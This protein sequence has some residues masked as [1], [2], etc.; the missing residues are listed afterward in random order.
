MRMKKCE[1]CSLVYPDKIEKCVRCGGKLNEYTGEKKKA[2]PVEDARE[3]SHHWCDAIRKV[4][5]YVGVTIIFIGTTIAI[6]TGWEERKW[7]TFLIMMFIAFVT[8]LIFLVLSCVMECLIYKTFG[9]IDPKK[10]KKEK[11][12]V[13]PPWAGDDDTG[14]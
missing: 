6:F 4:C 3:R 14:I 11:R 5:Y 8:G 9:R 2:E 1:Y 13:S 7:Q 12:D 10:G